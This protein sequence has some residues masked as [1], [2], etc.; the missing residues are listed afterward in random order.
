MKTA[1]TTLSNSLQNLF[2]GTE[3]RRCS[4][5]SVDIAGSPEWFGYIGN[6]GTVN[7]SFDP[8]G[9]ATS[10]F[11]FSHSHYPI[12]K[13]NKYSNDVYRVLSIRDPLSRIASFYNML[14]KAK[15]AQKERFENVED[16]ILTCHP[17][18]IFCQLYFLDQNLSLSGAKRELSQL[19]RIL[20]VEESDN[21]QEKISA[22]LGR[23][24]PL[25]MQNKGNYKSTSSKPNLL[26]QLEKLISKHPDYSRL[27]E[28]EYK[29]YEL[30][31]TL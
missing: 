30:A 25:T 26:N 9:C 28:K 13:F 27:L 20:I 15:F 5:H 1:S 10:S 31:K 11:N 24:I 21:W 23:N 14:K 8:L 18:Y 4:L 7:F 17:D 6:K 19:N 16:F 29:L 22:D 2:V 12:S 3:S